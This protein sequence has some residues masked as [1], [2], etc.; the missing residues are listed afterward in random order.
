MDEK[1]LIKRLNAG[2]EDAF[3]AAFKKHFT[4]LSLYAE[5]YVRDKHIA[6]EIVENFFCDFWENC[7]GIKIESNLTGYLVKSIQNRCLKYLRHE[8]VKQKYIESCQYL[9]TDREL[10]EPVSDD[11]PE[12][13]LISHELEKEIS[14]AIESLPDK[15]RKIFLL[16]RFDNLTYRKIAEKLGISVNTVKTQMARALQKLRS[17]LKDY[18][19]KY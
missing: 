15:C 1:D 3:E 10:L 12:A 8:K 18:L 13:L 14:D 11:Y 19:I 7:V 4:M 9:F 16:N 5:H 17:H 2:D 6:R